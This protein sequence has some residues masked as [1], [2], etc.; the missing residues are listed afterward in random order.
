MKDLVARTGRNMTDSDVRAYSFAAVTNVDALLTVDI[1][2]PEI[3]P[4]IKT[5][6]FSGF[7]WRRDRSGQE[8]PPTT[9]FW[10]G[11]F[12]EYGPTYRPLTSND[13]L[14]TWGSQGTGEALSAELL[15]YD[16]TDT[17]RLAESVIW[18]HWAQGMADV[19]SSMASNAS[20]NNLEDIGGGGIL[21]ISRVRRQ[22]FSLEVEV[23][24]SKL[25]RWRPRMDLVEWITESDD[26]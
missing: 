21:A 18:L 5:R 20:V 17:A 10:Y 4:R 19:D 25:P 7:D 12:R 3:P 15:A 23:E 26:E 2:G 16:D 9:T 11:L 8:R 22:L 13:K 6:R 24:I 1:T 14:S